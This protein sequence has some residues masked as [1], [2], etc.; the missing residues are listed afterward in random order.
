MVFAAVLAPLYLP[1]LHLVTLATVPATFLYAGLGLLASPV[2]VPL[3][4]IKAAISAA[5]MTPLYL[6]TTP[7]AAPVGFLLAGACVF[8]EVVRSFFIVLT[9]LLWPLY[10]LC[11]WWKYSMVVSKVIVTDT[12]F[13]FLVPL[14]FSVLAVMLP[15]AFAP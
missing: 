12:I 10:F 7:V 2:L 6:L 11:K 5:I 1:V 14:R 3:L 15:K 9:P 4:M 13:P 8:F